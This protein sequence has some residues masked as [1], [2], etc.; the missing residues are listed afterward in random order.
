MAGQYTR[1]TDWVEETIEETLIFY[2]LLRRNH[3]HMKSTN[4]LV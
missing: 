3:K 2:R 4:M 1:R